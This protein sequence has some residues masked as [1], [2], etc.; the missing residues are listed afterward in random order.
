[1]HILPEEWQSWKILADKDQLDLF[2]RSITLGMLERYL[3][4]GTPTYPMATTLHTNG[5][6]SI[7]SETFETPEAF[8]SAIAEQACSAQ[9]L[10]LS[11]VA[12]DLKH[13][14]L[15][16]ITELQ[17]SSIQRIGHSLDLQ[18]P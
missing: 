15:A 4:Y 7:Y 18:N 16:A 5:F 1:M 12:T 3:V 8:I 13:T 11:A 6:T 9:A 14:K 2:H 10:I 17:T